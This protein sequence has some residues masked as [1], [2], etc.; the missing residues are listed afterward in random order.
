VPEPYEHPLTIAPTDIDGLGHVNNT[1]YVRW[2]QEAATA[3]WLHLAPDED[4]AQVAWVLRRHEIDYRA[5]ALP[6]DEVVARTWVG[7]AEGLTFER[8][9]EILRASDRKVL[10]VSRT[11]WCPINIATG[12]PTRVRPELRALFSTPTDS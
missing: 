10:A 1:V 9:V 3:H 2:V 8:H 12:R 6:E 11:L 5:P 7:T 4:T